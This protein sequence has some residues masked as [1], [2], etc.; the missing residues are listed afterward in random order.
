MITVPWALSSKDPAESEFG[1][2]RMTCGGF[3]DA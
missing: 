3:D 1:M 2:V